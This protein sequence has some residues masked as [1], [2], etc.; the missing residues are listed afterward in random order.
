MREF[1][2]EFTEAR[3]T[4][5]REDFAMVVAEAIHEMRTEAMLATPDDQTVEENELPKLIELFGGLLGA[6]IMCKLFDDEEDE[7]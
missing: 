6:E 5:T 7:Y 2:K 4:I 3:V 1:D